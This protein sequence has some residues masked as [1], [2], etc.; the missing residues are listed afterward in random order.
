[1][2]CL[3]AMGASWGGLHAL[4]EVLG[5]LPAELPAAVVVA[6]H[7]SVEAG[8]LA[9]LLDRRSA[10]RVHEADDKEPLRAG[11]VLIAPPDYHLLVENDSVALSI[12]E[13]VRFSRPSIDVLFESAASA[14]GERVVGVVLTGSN[15]DG[16]AGLA[17]IRRRGGIA[18]VQDPAGAERTEMPRAALA[19]CPDAQVR[20]LDAIAS[21]LTRICGMP[22]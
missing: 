9:E 21:E 17:A 19:A 5:Q 7:R 1:M 4:G 10:L 12:D 2:Q 15:D 3:I 11:E 14:H 18:I 20:P 8:P 16:A 22:A 13:P 6:Q